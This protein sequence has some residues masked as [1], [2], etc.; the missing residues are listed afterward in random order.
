[1]AVE[2]QI[3]SEGIGIVWVLQENSGFQAGTAEDC[4]RFFYD[5]NQ[6]S[7]GLC[8]GDGESQP[9][10]RIFDTSNFAVGRGFDILIRKSDM[11]LIYVTTH[12]TPGGNDN[13]TGAELL[14]EMR[15]AIGR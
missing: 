5:Q 2:D 9:T 13:L 11:R 6:S 7:A 14:A 8:V 4:A 12:G 1:M 3:I 10:A 15:T